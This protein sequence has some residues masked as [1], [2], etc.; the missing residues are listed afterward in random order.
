M[1]SMKINKDSPE[2]LIIDNQPWLVA[3]LLGV[4]MLAFV[5]AGLSML[6]TD[7]WVLGLFFSVGGGLFFV[8]FFWAFVRRNQLILDRHAATLTLRRRTLTGYRETVHELQHLERAIVETSRS[9]KTN[10]H[11]MALVLKGGM[12]AGTHP[13]TSVYTSGRGADRAADAVN[14]WLDDRRRSLDS[15]ASEP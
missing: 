12:D 1:L 5:G 2:L 8:F 13:F 15:S 3:A 9:D 6:T 10:T 11:R 4:M 14:A 7:E